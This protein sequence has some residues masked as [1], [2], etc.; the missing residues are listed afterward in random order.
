MDVEVSVVSKDSDLS[1]LELDNVK[2]HYKLKRFSSS[3][4]KSA[5]LALLLLLR[6]Y[7]IFER[8]LKKFPIFN[9]PVNEKWDVI[10]SSDI[11]L[12][13]LVFEL[14][15]ECETRVVLDA[16]EFYPRQFEHN[17]VWRLIQK[18]I[19]TWLT[20]SYTPKVDKLFSVSRK[21]CEEYR[22]ISHKEVYFLPSYANYHDL[23]PAN[24]GE[25][26]KLIHHGHSGA[27]RKIEDMIYLMD[28]L[29]DRFILDMYLMSDYSDEYGRFIADLAKSRKN[30]NLLPP[31]ESKE[32]IS[33]GNKYDIGLCMFP[34][35]TFNLKY[36]LSNKIFEF[37][38]SRLC[39]AIGGIV[40]SHYIID[41]FNNG[42]YS[43]S[44][45][46]ETLS[47]KINSLTYDDIK[48]LK[49]NSHHA[50]KVLCAEEQFSS[51]KNVVEF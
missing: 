29:D 35:T 6:Q 21:L 51:F 39:L 14:K 50:A 22:K 9:P 45:D 26:I 8:Y 33:V 40:E 19:M 25:I 31:I 1:S 47:A 27:N 15:G 36:S 12:L 4:I 17:F 30:V 46:V 28:K 18:P 43:A 2:K 24:T 16:R 3:K 49:R 41:E 38:Q 7:K 5:W 37:V 44:A 34:D 23:E 13:P 32:L 48:V 11:L 10:I 20:Y 42:I